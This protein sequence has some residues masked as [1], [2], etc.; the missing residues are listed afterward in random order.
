MAPVIT[1]LVFRTNCWDET[2]GCVIETMGL[3]RPLAETT[4]EMEGLATTPLV[5]EEAVEITE[6]MEAG[7]GKS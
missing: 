3:V 6:E 4:V 5:T 1:P 7:F 2:G